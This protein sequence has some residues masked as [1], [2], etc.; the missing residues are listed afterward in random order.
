MTSSGRM[1][2]AAAH[3]AEHPNVNS[4]E[5]LHFLL[6]KTPAV[7][8]RCGPGPDYPTA[9]MS[10]SIESRF[11]FSPQEFL[12]DAHF[13]EKNIHPDDL[14]N[15]QSQ[16]RNLE[17][18]GTICCEYRLRKKNGPYV[19]VHDDFSLILDAN[20]QITGLIGTLFDINDRIRAEQAFAESQERL[21]LALDGAR[22]GLW[23]H[24]FPS[25]RV[26]RSE[27]W[28]TMLGYSLDEIDNMANIWKSLIH[29]DD[30]DAV[31]KTAFEH[32][33]GQI[34]EF[35]VEHRMR[36][37]TGEWKWILNWGRIL[38]RDENGDPIRAAGVHLDI[39]DR[40]E[41]ELRLRESEARVRAIFESAQDSIFVK[42]PDLRY[43][44]VNPALEKLFGLTED[45][46]IGLTDEELFGPE[47]AAQHRDEDVRVLAGEVLNMQGTKKIQG[48][49][50]TF[51]VIKAPLRDVESNVIGLCGIARDV[52]ETKRLQEFAVRAQRLETA[53]RVAGQVAHDFNNLLGPLT[54]FPELI[55][56]ML[57]PGHPAL[58]LIDLIENSAH[59]MAE[60]N[61]QLLTLGRRGHYSQESLDL[62]QSVRD[63]LGQ[64]IPMPDTV[65]VETDLAKNL[66]RI[67]GGASQ[68]ARA[69]SNLV[70][71]ACDEMAD[72]GTLSIRTENIYVDETCGEGKH[73]PKGEY[74]K[75]TL[76]DTG[77]GMSRATMA[78]MFEPFFTT[79]TTDRKRGS[80]LGLSVVHAVVEDHLGY[81]DCDSVEG[82]GTSFS[83]YFPAT[84]DATEP[85]SAET[86]GGDESILVVDDDYIQREVSRT[87]LETLG[88]QVNAVASGELA[89]AAV[90]D[91]HPNLVILD[92]IMPGGIDGTET[93]RKLREIDPTQ[94]AIVVSGFAESERVDEA[95]DLGAGAFLRKPLTLSAIAR[96]VRT[97]L[98]R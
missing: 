44:S 31:E 6:A 49:A 81:I 41:A 27:N 92:M 24:H 20:G 73:I 30:L 10:Q 90:R 63:C 78:R 66:L 36:T 51:D 87:L 15:F 47:V 70:A 32:E 58:D 3:S 67:N 56:N 12:E 39:S 80:G 1:D 83:L 91:G 69:L 61:Q 53:G 38:E 71:N 16:M 98:D 42:D 2:P 46:I 45:D 55:K 94:R 8:Y 88:Y 57:P 50:R 33:S 14:P 11:G 76:T 96:A 23:D 82:Q 60:I 84:R 17:Q 59:Q 79:K 37:K 72:F 25:G 54:A 40:K 64:I 93:L 62:N 68:I 26:I 21:A 75:L 48:R 19:W 18:Q 74:V 28:A 34:P 13:L 85:T 35:L 4:A 29:P 97:E 86:V 5:A 52:T 65:I 77:G 9:F 89:L 95:L 22:L 7:V 43:V